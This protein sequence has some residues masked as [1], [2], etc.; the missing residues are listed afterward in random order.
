MAIVFAGAL[1]WYGWTQAEMSGQ[2]G[3]QGA[4]LFGFS[5]LALGW[6]AAQILKTAIQFLILGV[7]LLVSLVIFRARFEAITGIDPVAWLQEFFG[8]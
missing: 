7:V 1:G 5:G 8:L 6:L 2:P 3:W 4:L